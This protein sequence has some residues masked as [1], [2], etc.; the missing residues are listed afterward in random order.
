[1][2]LGGRH[3]AQY[4]N[5]HVRWPTEDMIDE[6]VSMSSCDMSIEVAHY[7]L[8]LLISKHLIEHMICQGISMLSWL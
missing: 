2:S 7:Y 8:K 3:H 1:M 6:G 4:L 5:V